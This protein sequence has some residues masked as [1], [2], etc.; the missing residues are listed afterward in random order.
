MNCFNIIYQ[1]PPL[2]PLTP[3]APLATLAPPQL[4]HCLD[5]SKNFGID[6]FEYYWFIFPIR[7]KYQID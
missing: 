3:L 1:F 5:Q 4:Y 6:K 2:T 7:E